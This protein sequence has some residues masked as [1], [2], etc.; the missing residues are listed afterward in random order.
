MGSENVMQ[1]VSL[2]LRHNLTD[3]VTAS[4]F[5]TYLTV[6]VALG[7]I[8]TDEEIDEFVDIYDRARAKPQTKKEVINM[9]CV[10]TELTFVCASFIAMGLIFTG[11]SDAKIDPKKDIAAL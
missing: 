5:G 10:I 6:Y 9:K 2:L 3:C 4:P 7:K 1:T 8:L 11:L